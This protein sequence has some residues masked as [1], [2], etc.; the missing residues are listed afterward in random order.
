MMRLLYGREEE[1]NRAVGREF[2]SAIGTGLGNGKEIAS[3][4][5]SCTHA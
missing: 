3:N 5:Y 2:L 1:M 4:S